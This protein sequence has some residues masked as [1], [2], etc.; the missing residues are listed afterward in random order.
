M[1]D[2][3]VKK[4]LEENLSLTKENHKI[5]AGIRNAQRRANMYRLIYWIVII[6]ITLGAYY[7]VQPYIES[8]TGYYS[9][10]SGIG[11]DNAKEGVS[12]IPDFKRIQDLLNQIQN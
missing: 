11:G 5:L 7:F 12:S 1:V 2:T 10:I 8:L 4:I 6:A 9:A 3:E